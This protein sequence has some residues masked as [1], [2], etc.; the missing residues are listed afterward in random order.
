MPTP[1][2][3]QQL[4]DFVSNTSFKNIPPASLPL[5]RNA[6]TDCVAVAIAAS[7]ES[8]VDQVQEL[9]RQ[10]FRGECA[11]VLFVGKDRLSV[12]GASMVNGTASHALHFDD[13]ALDAHPST[14]LVPAL[15]ACFDGHSA[16]RTED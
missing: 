12:G 11:A 3:A 2:I 9:A 1:T 13:A 4:A 5:V 10:A 16:V 7:R 15:M 14:V 6:F 8:V